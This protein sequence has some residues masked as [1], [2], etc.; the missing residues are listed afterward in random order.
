MLSGP[1]HVSARA[2]QALVFKTTKPLGYMSLHIYP[3][4]AIMKR[5]IR[6]GGKL[7]D[8][9]Q[10][11]TVA[12]TFSLSPS[13]PLFS[14]CLFMFIFA[15]NLPLILLY[16]SAAGG[17]FAD[18]ISVLFSILICYTGERELWKLAI[19]ERWW[20]RFAPSCRVNLY[21]PLNIFF[22]SPPGLTICPHWR[23]LI[24]NGDKEV[25]PSLHGAHVDRAYFLFFSIVHLSLCHI[26]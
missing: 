21:S 9:Q 16:P 14:A 7:E 23:Y 26:V 8:Y 11:F 15:L 5:S 19:E 3:F 2:V 17:R 10:I 12:R 1:L 13:P 18:T 20:R 6:G 4:D 22:S 24:V 25:M